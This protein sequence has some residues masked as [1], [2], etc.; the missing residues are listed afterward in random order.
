MSGD[1]RPY[2]VDTD[3]VKS[4]HFDLGETQSRM[5]LRDPDALVL[6]YTRTMM[7]GLLFNP[8]PAR[9]AMIGLGGG[10]LA[11][12][13][14]R[15]LPEAVIDVAEVNPR[16]LDLRDEFRI[17]PDDARLSIHLADG[18]DFIRRLEF[19]QALDLLLVDAYGP[20]GIP[21]HLC[22]LEFHGD[23]LRSL[24]AGGVAVF[25][26]FHGFPDY[27]RCI[28]HIRALFGESVLIVG[29]GDFSN[30]IVFAWRGPLEDRH[31]QAQS[32]PTRIPRRAWTQL[33]AAMNRVR[34][35]WKE[36]EAGI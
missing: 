25:N 21:E 13:C 2:C 14:H 15:H 31:L 9:I 20:G 10:S 5:S 24:R 8:T 32:R 23:C 35:A 12:F 18:A 26:L 16:V 6:K 11:K 30:D 36:R 28:A 22:T 3:L 27:E 34:E 19:R 1:P 4:L 17:P 29:D 33:A 7:G